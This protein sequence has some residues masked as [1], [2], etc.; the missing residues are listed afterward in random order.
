[1][2]GGCRRGVVPIIITTLTGGSVVPTYSDTTKRVFEAALEYLKPQLTA[3]EHRAV[4][5]LFAREEATPDAVVA[6]LACRA[7]PE[8]HDH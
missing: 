4:A 1:V 2:T 7:E 5:E 3:E 6:A 8:R